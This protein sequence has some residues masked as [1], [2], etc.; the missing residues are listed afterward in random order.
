MTQAFPFTPDAHRRPVSAL[1]AAEDSRR[2]VSS[3]S[4]RAS[5]VSKAKTVHIDIGKRSIRSDEKIVSPGP[6]IGQDGSS[7]S[8]GSCDE[9]ASDEEDSSAANTVGARPAAKKQ[10]AENQ[11]LPLEKLKW[12]TIAQASLRYPGFSEKSLRHLQAQAE[13]YQRY[14]KAGLKSNG[15][16]NCLVRPAGQRKILINA[17]KFEAWLESCSLGQ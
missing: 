12:L 4:S 11:G 9:G 17:E 16:I 8:E 2:S 1:Y 13:A 15:F 5:V 3:A 14:P 10:H 6:A 7:G